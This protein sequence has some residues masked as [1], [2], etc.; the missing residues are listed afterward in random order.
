MIVSRARV[1]RIMIEIG[2]G[3]LCDRLS[4]LRL[5]AKHG[6]GLPSAP[7]LRQARDELENRRAALDL[8][9]QVEEQE[10]ELAEVN[11]MLWE[12][13][14]A[15]RARERMGDFSRE[16]VQLA[17]QVPRLNDRRSALKKRIDRACGYVNPA[18]TKIYLG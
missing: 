16:Y 1:P 17:H 18:E 6:Q 7:A 15:I 11:R 13:E 8:G 14:S 3:E 12:I 4:I 5:K 9:P 2:P 10:D